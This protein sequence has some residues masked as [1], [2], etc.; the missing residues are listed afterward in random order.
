MS[1]DQL[2]PVRTYVNGAE[3][4]LARSALEAA[5]IHAVVRRDDCGGV[6][7]SL[8]LLG[9]QLL[10]HPDDLA[11]ADAVLNTPALY[12]ADPEPDTSSGAP[13]VYDFHARTI[14]GADLSL[15]E[16]RGQVLLV[17]NVASRCGYTS[18]YD[19]LERLYRTHRDRGFAV[20]GFPCNQFGSQE[21][22]SEAEIRRFCTQQYGV[23]FPLFAKVDVNGANAHPLF[24][25]LKARQ[26]GWFGGSIRWN[27]TKF[28]VD[29]AGQ[30]V[31]RHGPMD[32]PAKIGPDIERALAGARDAA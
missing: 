26:R 32:A 8:W 14:D 21:P 1:I 24:E 20:L 18:Q 2:T 31:K 16:F 9:I 27:F 7:P 6:R 13:S 23:T 17:V 5:G 28:L 25:F 12:V 15:S 19:G 22:G 10:V 4:D 30:P 29:R 11:A 3:A